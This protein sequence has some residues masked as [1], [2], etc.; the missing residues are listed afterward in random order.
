MQVIKLIVL[1]ITDWFH[2]VFT[3]IHKNLKNFAFVLDTVCPYVTGAAIVQSYQE[4]G[5]LA[6]GGEWLIP[7]FF[8]ITSMLLKE[9]ANRTGKGLTV[10]VPKK[11]FTEVSEDGEVTIP[12]TRIEEL[13]LYVCDLEDWLERKGMLR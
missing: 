2:A 10:P 7:L 13:L 3:W 6:F 5:Q 9:I 12:T 4:R 8:W 1:I 11:R